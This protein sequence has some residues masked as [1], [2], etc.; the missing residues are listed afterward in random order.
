MNIVRLCTC[1]LVYLKSFTCKLTTIFLWVE[2]FTIR[3]MKLQ[4]TNEMS[5]KV[6]VCWFQLSAECKSIAVSYDYSNWFF[7]IPCIDSYVSFIKLFVLSMCGL[8]ETDWIGACIRMDFAGK[9]AS[10]RIQHK[11]LKHL[12]ILRP[13]YKFENYI[14]KFIFGMWILFWWETIKFKILPDSSTNSATGE[15]QIYDVCMVFSAIKKKL[16]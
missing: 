7:Q 12:E 1:V 8:F 4:F 10:K 3:K 15:K 5:F 2:M 16:C 6:F 11:H 14:Y 9:V 13:T